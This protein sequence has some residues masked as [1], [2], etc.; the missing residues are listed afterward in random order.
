MLFSSKL[1]TARPGAVKES[2][3][4]QTGCLHYGRHEIFTFS[5]CV[6]TAILLPKKNGDTQ[7]S[8]AICSI[9]KLKLFSLSNYSERNL[10]GNLL[11]QLNSCLVRTDFLNCRNH[12]SLA[13]DLETEFSKLLGNLDSAY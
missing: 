7:K 11:V 1:S 3:L 6:P 2:M 10:N 5:E 9:L 12:D 13:V 8:V 4:Q